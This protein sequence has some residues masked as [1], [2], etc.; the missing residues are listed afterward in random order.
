[1]AGTFAGYSFALLAYYDHPVSSG[2]VEETN[3]KIQTLER[4]TYGYRDTEFFKLR[5]PGLH[6]AKYALAG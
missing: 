2:P 6:E 3:N 1:M 5:V 4:Q